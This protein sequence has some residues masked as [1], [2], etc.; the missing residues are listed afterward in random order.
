MLPADPIDPEIEAIEQKYRREMK[1]NQLIAQSSA[2]AISQAPTQKTDENT[3][4]PADLLD[5]EDNEDAE[6]VEI[7]H[8]PSRDELMGSKP[9]ETDSESDLDS[10]SEIDL[11]PEL[12]NNND[13]SETDHSENEIPSQQPSHPNP[14]GHGRQRSDRLRNTSESLITT[15]DSDFDFLNQMTNDWGSM[16]KKMTH[17]QIGGQSL[18]S[19][20]GAVTDKKI[21]L[22]KR[23]Q[24]NNGDI[25][26]TDKE[27]IIHKKYR[28]VDPSIHEN[29]ILE[30]VT[31]DKATQ[32]EDQ[33]MITQK[34]ILLQ[35]KEL[36][37]DFDETK[38]E[39]FVIRSN[40]NLDRSIDLLSE[41][42]QTDDPG[43]NESFNLLPEVLNTWN[44][45]IDMDEIERGF[46]AFDIEYQARNNK[47]K[48]NDQPVTISDSSL[49]EQLVARFGPP[50]LNYSTQ[51]SSTL[52]PLSLAE[53]IFNWWKISLE[54]G[55]A[56][57]S[58]SSSLSP[59]QVVFP[60]HYDDETYAK[61]L[62]DQEIALQLQNELNQNTN[63]KN[64]DDQFPALNGTAPPPGL[65]PLPKMSGQ[66]KNSSS[67]GQKEKLK[68]LGQLFPEMP[69]ARLE[70]FLF[71]NNGN[72]GQAAKTICYMTEKDIKR[73]HDKREQISVT[74]GSHSTSNHSSR[75]RSKSTSRQESPALAF[76][77]S[78]QDYPGRTE[79]FKL[80]EQAR[81]KRAKARDHIRANDGLTA[82]Y[83]SQ[84][85][86]QLSERA[87]QAHKKAA[88]EIFQRHNKKHSG[89]SVIDLHGLHVNEGLQKLRQ[90]LKKHKTGELQVITGR[91]RNSHH[92]YAKLRRAVESYLQ[93]NKY[94]FSRHAENQGVVKIKLPK[95]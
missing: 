62:H 4:L 63:R 19:S 48:T 9:N 17:D 22:D 65:G 89:K 92:N 47:S 40:F 72:V 41:D 73:V 79:A 55:N 60:N 90:E 6:L 58:L 74:G 70:E 44:E 68:K 18:W 51:S 53:E 91:G 54:T 43:T 88:D 57:A 21:A 52:I 20:Q 7:S 77:E 84:E 13:D 39:Q 49:F 80:E 78:D 5:D 34:R 71:D 1:R 8:P 56:H 64:L 23:T 36:F 42:N 50:C 67:F 11:P 12:S 81:E 28:S 2:S 95:K 69:E 25:E 45:I 16:A 30:G 26:S 86:A 83:Y 93:S 46:E 82:Q 85:A 27:K 75:S 37:P 10:E 38:L 29:R 31:N 59:T 33:D 61:T 66:W 87:A 32:T 14:I 94:E 76:P 15:E 35:L 24:T 3:C